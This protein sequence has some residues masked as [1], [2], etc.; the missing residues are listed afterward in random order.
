MAILS[1]SVL[2]EVCRRLQENWRSNFFLTIWS[3]SK[4]Y[5]NVIYLNLLSPI[6]KFM[7]FECFSIFISEFRGPSCCQ[8]MELI[9][10]LRDATDH[11]FLGFKPIFSDPSLLFLSSLSL[12]PTFS[13]PTL[14]SVVIS[15]DKITYRVFQCFLLLF[16]II[17]LVSGK[18][19]SCS[20]L[21]PAPSIWSPH[22]SCISKCCNL[23]NGLK[24]N[25]DSI[26]WHIS[27]S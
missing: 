8:Q 12:G 16:R 24:Q 1:F 21:F 10:I 22:G 5:I 3:I 26:T 19:S 4:P 9:Q 13:K 11:I 20:S 23:K 18:L 6:F 27:C 25:N 14:L 7:F 15:K 17:L 2:H